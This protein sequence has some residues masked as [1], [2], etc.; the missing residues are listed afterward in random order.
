MVPNV[1][2]DFFMNGLYLFINY[3]LDTLLLIFFYRHY[4]FTF[5]RDSGDILV[6]NAWFLLVNN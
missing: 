5:T 1:D 6:R 4:E 2:A 3:R